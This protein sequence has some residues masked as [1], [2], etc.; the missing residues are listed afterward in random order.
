MR[1]QKEQLKSDLQESKKKLEE[2]IIQLQNKGSSRDQDKKQ[3]DMI[4]H[5]ENEYK[6]QISNLQESHEKYTSELLQKNKDL[7]AKNHLLQEKYELTFRDSSSSTKTLE[8][9]LNDLEQKDIIQSRELSELKQQRDRMILENQKTIEKERDILKTKINEIER[10][11][12]SSE[13]DKSSLRFEI[14]KQQARWNTEKDNLENIKQEMYEQIMKLEKKNENLM[15]QNEK[16]K[17]KTKNSRKYNKYG[18]VNTSSYLDSSQS[19]FLA[20]KY[21]SISKEIDPDSYSNNSGKENRFK[22]FTKYIGDGKEGDK[23]S[24]G[25]HE[26]HIEKTPDNV[27]GKESES[28]NTL[29]P[30]DNKE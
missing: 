3:L 13:S 17:E 12:L 20:G 15:I 22:T 16:L 30:R 10:K 8:K 28:T 7:E 27:G 2:A 19:R 4:N 25:S 21:T 23:K 6:D 5:L 26:Y 11:F 24:V 29:S 9:R 18:G 14:E 1:E